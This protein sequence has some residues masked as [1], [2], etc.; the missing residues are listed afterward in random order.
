VR[1]RGSWQH[2]FHID[3]GFRSRVVA[4]KVYANSKICGT[5]RCAATFALPLFLLAAPS[6]HAQRERGE[7]QIEVRDPQGQSVAAAAELLSES[8]QFKKEFAIGSDGKFSA[9][10]LPFG[11][12]RLNVSA[13]GFAAWSGLVEIRN[14]LPV[15]LTVTL[16]V[17]AVNTK[18]EVTDAAT[19][20][21]PSENGTVVSLGGASLREHA[22]PQP[23]RNLSDAVDDQPGWLYEANGSLHPRG[24]EY[25]LQYVVDGIP[26]TQNRSPAFAPP[27]DSGDVESMRVMTAGYPAE[28]G[29]KL[30]GVVELMTEKNPPAGLHGR[31]EAGG[32]SFESLDGAAEL[33]YSARKNHYELSGQGLHTDRYLDPPVLQNY[34]N[35]GN[36][37]GVSASYGRDFFT[38]DRLR[39]AYFLN[40][41]RFAVPNERVQQAAGQH[42]NSATSETGGQIFYQHIG[43]N[44]L[45]STFSAGVR[46]STFTLRSNGLATPVVVTQDRGYREGYVRADLAG[47]HG[48]QDWKLGAD[49]LFT[50]VHESLAY[51]ITDP[52][53]FDP[54]TVSPFSFDQTHWDVEPA[55]YAQDSVHW[56]NWS[57]SAGLRFD[58]YGFLVR[59][60]ALSPRLGVSRYLHPWNMLLHVS[61]DRVFQTPAMENLLLASSPQVDSLNPAVLRLPLRPSRGNFFE[62]GITQG[63]LGKLRLDANVFRRSFRDFADDDV[64]LDTGVSFPIAFDGARVFGEELRL[65]VSDWHQFSGFFSYSNQSAIAHGPVTGGLFV[66]SD[67]AG[68]LTDNSKFAVTQDQRNTLRARIRAQLDKRLWAAVSGDYG[69]GLPIELAAS[70][71]VNSLLAHY[72]TQI[73]AR[74]DLGRGRVKPNFSLQIAA[75]AELYHKELRTLTVQLEAANLTDRVNVL[76]FAGL[77]SGTAVAA[78]RSA[79]ARLRFTF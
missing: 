41:V 17:A 26:L 54:D 64:L 43:S 52:S 69:S 66:G 60:S 10:E 73:L 74:V 13:E 39:I 18:V 31:F 9:P 8:N 40:E 58:H 59:E 28:Y 57:L 32:G 7:L 5:I 65:S 1:R 62:G 44:N 35:W 25:Q 24:S 20:L 16:G 2:R 4:L 55:I 42:Q 77:F 11:V 6:A 56:A 76:N 36:S 53:Q 70:A 75:G 27:F 67:A 23:G 47:H 19:L 3:S 51:Q 71:N 61:Y 34:T 79:T 22:A 48:H 21:D 49:L 12:Y 63:L 45:L 46:D 78:P 33:G 15:H 72:G 68:A 38:A 29:R 50:K 30:G 14:G 37:S